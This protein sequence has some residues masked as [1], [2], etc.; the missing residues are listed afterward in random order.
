MQRD[1]DIDLNAIFSEDD[2]DLNIGS[3][4]EPIVIEDD[5]PAL[6]LE[7]ENEEVEFLVIGKRIVLL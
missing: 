7:V 6:E 5:P 2:V 1:E 3:D 4:D